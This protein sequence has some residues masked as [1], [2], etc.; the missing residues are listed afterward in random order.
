SKAFRALEAEEDEHGHGDEDDHDEDHGDEHDEDEARGLVPGSH[1]RGH[2]GAFGLS[3]V[4]ERGFVGASVSRMEAFYGLPGGHGHGHGHDHEH[5]SE[6][7]HDEDHVEDE[8]TPVLD[9]Q[10][11]RVDIEAGLSDPL[12]GFSSLNLRIG[13]NNYDHQEIEADGAVASRFDNEATDSRLELSHHPLL[14]WNGAIG[15]QYTDRTFSTLGEEAF[16]P[17]VDTRSTGVFW[18]AERSFDNFSVE[19]G[20]RAE[21]VHH[22][23]AG[24]IK[25]DFTVESASLGAIIPLSDIWQL[26]LTADYSTRAPTGEELYSDGPHLA[27]GT[28]E[29]GDIN[30]DEEQATG[31]SATVSGNGDQ[32]HLEASLYSTRFH[33]YIYQRATGDEEDELPVLQ[34]DQSDAR[35]SGIDA[36]VSLQ[37]HESENSALSARL[38]YDK[39]TAK[40]NQSAGT[41]NRHLPR[42]PPSAFGVGFDY[43]MDVDGDFIDNLKL[44]V[45]FRH[46]SA[47][48]DVADMEL[49]T[50]SYRDLR[51]YLTA[52]KDDLEW[53]LH[54]LNLTD[55]EQRNHSSFIKDLVPQPGRSVET[56]FRYRF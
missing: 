28:F 19:A 6:S 12:T 4:G 27:T 26:N 56:G 16:V 23:P 39:V 43:D 8:G 29:K 18:V 46:V 48:K 35:Y 47:Q 21:K 9:M 40:L 1:H 22:D 2:G 11:T 20:V 50:E 33:D 55:D 45:D 7:E 41:E 31:F 38:T 10:Q 53:F 54:G 3:W 5:E 34:F 25:R 24:N 52:T 44:S 51:V 37:L 49:P 32:W 36:M 15:I 42:I 13:H 14:G 17:P 30:L